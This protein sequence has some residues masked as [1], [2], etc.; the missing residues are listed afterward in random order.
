MRR[1]HHGDTAVDD[2]EWLR[3]KED[4][5]VLAHLEA[6]NSW[7][8]QQLAGLAPLRTALFTEIKDRTQETDL[9]VPTRLDAAWYYTRTQEGRQ[10]PVHAR[11]AASDVATADGW[12]PPAVEPGV[13]PDGE[14]VLLDQNAEA[15][16]H[17]F[18][19]LGSF[20]VSGDG[21]RLAYAVDTTGDERYTLRVRDLTT[22]ADLPDVVEDTAPGAV[23]APDG[24]HVFYLTV[25]EAWRPYRVWRHRIGTPASEDVLVLEEPD[26]RFWLGVG[27][28]RSRRY[29]VVELGSKTT[30]EAWVLEADDPTGAFRRVWE[31]RDGVEYSVEHVELPAAP[32]AG[33]APRDALLVLHNDGARNFELVLTDVPARPAPGAAAVPL[34]PAAAR[35]VVPHSADVRLD[36][37]E[38]FARHVALAYRADALPRVGVVDL[39][40]VEQGSP[41]PVTEIDVDEPLFSVGLDAN[42]DWRQPLLRVQHTSFV[43]PATVVDVDLS[44]GERH[45]RKRQPVLGGYDP[46]DYVQRRE[47]AVAEDGARVP[48]SL[49]WRRDAVT[50]DGQG[51]RA[52]PAPLVLYGYGAY[53]T[54][55]D[56]Y[57]SVPRLSLL[58]RGVV[59][60][61]AH[62]RGG[63]ELGRRW[64]DDGKL[65]AKPHTFTDFVACGRH[66][67]ST[68]WTEPGRMV[69]EGGSAGGLLVGAVTN[70][71]PELFAGVLAVVPFVDALTSML[72]PSLP[73]TVVEWDEWGDPLHDP[74]AYALMRS[75]T[76][77][78][79]VPD[80]AAHYPRVLATTSLH[81][82][83]VLYV[84]PAKW[85]ARLRAAGAPALLKIEMSAGHGGVSG[86]YA[87]WEEIAFENAWVL[88]VLGRADVRA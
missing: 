80:D 33:V 87:R 73:L 15:E 26:E 4:P 56:P 22:G 13:V 52:E 55:I 21:T 16:G 75:Y 49:V 14:Q 74:D 53:E 47:W 61:V 46:D 88:D 3:A 34:D 65:A 31:R 8:A 83:R 58:D 54:S 19:S 5:E 82:T 79:N 25:D 1:T 39:G 41:W 18:F 11:V 45:V 59:F 51:T 20:D 66:L 69:A 64:Y 78:E 38:A 77:Y 72:D 50:L 71:A 43:T 29:L 48:I 27:L 40:A 70:L 35:V 24:E 44:T 32:G 86:R 7:T 36:G 62:V 42:P 23:L 10:Y 9:S 84:E 12:T 2:Y 17:D 68:G 81:D 60:A 37:V 76:P 28:S 67:V 63:G 6:E 85:V 57:F 30:S